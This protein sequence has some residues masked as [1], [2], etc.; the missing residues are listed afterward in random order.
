METT[1]QTPCSSVKTTLRL[2]TEDQGQDC[3]V[4]Q[5][6]LFPRQPFQQKLESDLG[7][8]QCSEAPRHLSSPS[9]IDFKVYFEC[10]QT[11]IV[12]F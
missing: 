7:P 2:S 8:L 11:G 3:T 5:R 12:Q 1:A 6:A 10:N 9:S 4:P